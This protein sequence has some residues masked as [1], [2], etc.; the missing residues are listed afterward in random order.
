MSPRL[1]AYLASV[2]LIV[3]SAAPWQVSESTWQSGLE[4]AGLY[5]LLL[6]V[7]AGLLL[8]QKRPWLPVIGAIGAIC[9]AIT[10]FNVVDIARS[11]R[12]VVLDESAESIEVDWGLWLSVIASVA[13]TA[14][15]FLFHRA[16]DDRALRSKPREPGSA[17]RWIRANPALF[18][19][20]VLLGIGVVLRIWMTVVWSPAITGYSDT[21]IYF[22]GAVESVWSDPIRMVGYS[23]FLRLLHE[24]SPHLIAVVIVQHAMGLGAAVLLFL[25]MLRSGAPW[26][27]GLVPAAVIAIGGDELFIEHAALSDA[28]FVFLIAA[29]LYCTIRA[30]EDRLWWAALA[31][32]CAGLSVWDRTV[33][34]SLVMVMPVWLAFSSGRVTRRS[35]EVGLLSL[36]VALLTVG[37]YSAW[38]SAATDMP[39]A[40]TSNNAWNLYGRVAPWADCEEFTPPTGTEALCEETPAAERGY[41]SGEEYIY[42]GESP[43]QLLYGPPYVL[44]SDPTAMEQMQDWSEAVVRAQPLDY[45]HAVWRDTLRLFRPQAPAY[46]DLT[47]DAMIAYMLNGPDRY[48]GRNDFVESWQSQ[49]YPDDPPARHGNIEPFRVWEAMT[50]IVNLWM[51]ISLALCLASP[52]LLS[53]RARAA[54]ILFGLTALMLVFFP[55]VGKAYDYRFMV[56]AYAPLVAAAALGGW[57]LTTKVRLKLSPPHPTPG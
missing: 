26:W 54:A 55:I 12:E 53:G 39:G 21:G 13:L 20:E 57:G 29:M 42:G 40:L 41:R 17:E 32:L 33:G 7:L 14:S 9:V 6:A 22:T 23:M 10:L 11:T 28:L 38:R 24:L 46:G 31:G 5:T 56:P 43:A 8:T 47:A 37:V 19:I 34:L 50:R 15:A 52:W 25:A 18:A 2:T 35:L 27:L 16:V 48:S 36:A 45:L 51:L 3:G 49:L 30:S 4:G 44:A 1:A